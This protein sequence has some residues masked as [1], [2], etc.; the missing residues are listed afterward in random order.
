MKIIPRLGRHTAITFVVWVSAGAA[1]AG[2]AGQQQPV[3]VRDDP[4]TLFAALM[5]VL[6]HDRCVNCHGATDPY[7]GFYH[8]GAVPFNSICFNCHTASPLWKLAPSDVAFHGKNTRQLCDQFAALDPLNSPFLEQHVQID[9]LINQA[10]IG[11]RGGAVPRQYTQTPP[12]TKAEF[13]RAVRTWVRDGGAACSGWEGT[14]TEEQSIGGHLTLPG[15]IGQVTHWQEGTRT[16]SVTVKDGRATVTSTVTGF[17]NNRQEGGDNSCRITILSQRV[18]RLVD[19]NAPAGPPAP[20]VS[21]P[22]GT[23]SARPPA[24]PLTGQGSVRVGLDARGN[25]RIVVT[26]PA[27]TIETTEYGSATNTCGAPNPGPTQD[28]NRIT[29]DP[30]VIE[31]AGTLP[32][33]ANRRHLQ[34]QSEIDLTTQETDRTMGI[35]AYG[36][37]SEVDGRSI[38]FKLKRTWDLRRLP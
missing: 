11:R 35:E 34:G 7:R 9:D 29:W 26:P 6:K 24:V 28:S 23:P 19:Q 16:V 20:A 18:Y 3:S 10:F 31:I 36:A 13:I 5:P 14:I 1:A 22:P 33:P 12:M 8:P 25:Y 17:D 32:N 4:L 37:A 27:E 21:S 30:F 38:P 2:V 15:G